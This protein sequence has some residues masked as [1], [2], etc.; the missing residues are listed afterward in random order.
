LDLPVIYHERDSNGRLIEI[1]TT[2]LKKG[3]KGVIHCFS[4]NKTEL[5]QYLDLG[6]YIGIAGIVTIK[7]RGADLRK[8]VSNIPAERI[9]VETD[10][11][12]LTPV[13]EKNQTRRNEPAFVRSVLLKLAEVRSE[14]PGYLAD[15]IWENTCRLY[16]ID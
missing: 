12:Y 4:G 13:P 3:Q 1:L 9:L 16:G 2:Y 11:P 6:L 8:L 15:K 14:D 5:I 10:A 7:G